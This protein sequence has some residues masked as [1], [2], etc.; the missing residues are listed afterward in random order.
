MWP[1]L[2]NG[3][4]IFVSRARTI[5]KGDIITVNNHYGRTLTHRVLDEVNLTTKGD[6]NVFPEKPLLGK[7]YEMIGKLDYIIDDTP[8]N[9]TVS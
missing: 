5:E 1:L 9:R 3:D 8:K 7:S 6:N 4:S 2:K